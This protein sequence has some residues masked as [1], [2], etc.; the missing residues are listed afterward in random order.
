MATI[1]ICATVKNEADTVRALISDL[2]SQTLRPDEIVVVDGG[3][4]DGTPE[5]LTA[6]LAE[7]T[8]FKLIDFAGS[9]IAREGT[10]RSPARLEI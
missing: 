2:K 4:T 10:A 8:A 1:S 6:G 3:S 7:W 9:N 5:Q